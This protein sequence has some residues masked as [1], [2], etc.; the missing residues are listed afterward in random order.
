MKKLCAA[1]AC[2]LA[3]ALAVPALADN[4]YLIPDSDTRRLTEQEL[5][6]WQYDALGYVLN[7]IFARHGYHFN[8]GGQYQRYFESQDWYHESEKWS[9]NQEIY[10]HEMT[11]IEWANEALVKQVRKQMRD[12]GTT[13][14]DGRS[15]DAPRAPAQLSPGEVVFYTGGFARGQKFEVYSGPGR[16][17]LRGAD[18]KASVSTNDTVYLAGREGEWALVLYETNGG[19]MRAGWI[20]M[21]KATSSF[22]AQELSLAYQDAS[23][24][25]D[26]V[27][28]DDPSLGKAALGRLSAGEIVTYLGVYH[29]H[30][31]W[32]YVE[33]WLGDT[34]ARGF[35]PL[36]CVEAL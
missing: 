19:S 36:S 33:A 3:L 28:T 25:Q 35:V 7:E 27:L 31:D 20:D 17:Y 1:L 4:T 12:Q 23:L 8:E 11:N 21:R 30:R 5:W 32:A 22:A 29:S 2:A 9:T 14:P 16:A 24:T 13:N 6:A 15:L 18:G 26:C 34:P 10:Q